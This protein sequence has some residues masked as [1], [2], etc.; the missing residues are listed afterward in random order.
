[1]FS[2]SQRFHVH[3]LRLDITFRARAH[4]LATDQIG[5]S[6]KMRQR[7]GIGVMVSPARYLVEAWTEPEHGLARLNALLPAMR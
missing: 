7:A 1:M 4:L 6:A 3:D 2:P 5:E